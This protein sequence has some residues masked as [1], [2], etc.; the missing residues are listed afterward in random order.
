MSM[1]I[2]AAHAAHLF[3]RASRVLRA[4]SIRPVSPGDGAV[5]AALCTLIDLA[6]FLRERQPAVA[7]RAEALL[8]EFGIR[9]PWTAASAEGES[10]GSHR[11]RRP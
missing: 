9:T 3:W 11:R 7:G 1:Q 4:A 2:S 10:R 5:E 6:R 8:E